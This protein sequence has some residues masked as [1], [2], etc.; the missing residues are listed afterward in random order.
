MGQIWDFFQN[1]FNT[2]GFPPRWHCGKWSD[3]HGW[4]YIISDLLIWSAYFAMPIIIVRYISRKQGLRFERIYFLFA[5]F[6]LACGTTHLL[7]AIIFWYPFYRI[8]ALVRFATG[9]ISWITVY[10]LV[11]MMPTAFSLKSAEQL[12]EEVERRKIV[13]EQLRINNNLLT[14]TQNIAHLGHWQWDATNNKI[15]WSQT[16]CDI[17]EVQNPKDLTYQSYLTL[18]HPEDRPYLQEIIS[19]AIET[20]IF[21]EF[22]HRLIVK[23]GTVKT[24][25]ARGQVITNHKGEITLIGTAQDVTELKKNEQELLAKTKALEASNVELEKF[26]SI[27]SHDLREPLRKI[28]AFSSMLE[29]D[30]KDALNEKGKIYLE[31]IQGASARMQKLIDDILHFSLLTTELNDFKKVDLNEVIK[32][33]LSDLE[34]LIVTTHAEVIIENLPA[35]EG[36]ASQLGQLFFNLMN[37][38]IK[39]C[40]P[41]TVPQ[42]NISSVF[43]KG[44][45]LPA[46]PMKL[47][48]YKFSILGSPRYWENELFCQISITDN[49]IGFDEAYLDRIFT[50]FQRLHGKTDYEGTGIGL[51]VCKKVVDI[52]HGSI[53]A[54]STLGVG[55]TFIVLLPVSQKNFIVTSMQ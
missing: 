7:D 1:L 36:N 51:A 12:E 35:I 32:E 31:K 42:V 8:S 28:S 44:K 34:V 17:F 6:I 29:H 30:Q 55:T 41:G 9:I 25:H 19:K 39:F 5:A 3:F 37:N 13:E 49:G 22:Y 47:A 33:V 46:D 16:L 54:R 27:A 50:I 4:L 10:Y 43:I 48:Q 26:A 23:D 2:S 53:T 24:I 20:K 15:I 38:A 18:I 52:H 45:E 40:K 21:P 11:K 14:E